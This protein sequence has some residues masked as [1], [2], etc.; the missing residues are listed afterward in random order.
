MMLMKSRIL[1]FLLVL[2]LALSLSTYQ[3]GS[4]LVKINPNEELL[5]IVY[6]LAF[7]HD[8]FVIH[9][10]KYIS[11]V[12][13]WFG[14]Y[15]NHRAVEVLREYFKNAKRI[16]EKDYLLFV[17]DAY[18]LQFS[19]PPEMKRIYTEWQDQELD[20]IVDALRE[21]SRD[22]NFIEF[23]RKHENYYSEDLEVYTSAIALLPPDK[24]MKSYMN[25]TKVRFEFHFPYL[26]CIHGHSF[27]E[28]ISETV[29]YGSGG[30][31]PLVRRNPPQTYWGFLRAKD[32]VFG[33]PLNSVYVNN[34]EFDRVWILEFIYHEL[35]HDLTSPKL[36]EYYGYKVR[37]LRY[38]EDTIEEDMPY[39]ATYDIH[40]W[41]E[42]TMIYESFADGWAYFALSRINK[43]YA[44]L[45]L[46]MQKAWGEFWIEEVVELYEKYARIAVENNKPL[47]EY[48][49][50]ILTEL[51]QKVPE[52]KAKAL[53]KERVPVTPLRALDDVVKEGEVLIVYGTQNPDKS[54]VDYDRKTAEIVR[55]YL[56]RFYSQWTGEIKVEVKSDLEVTDEDL[57]KDLILIGGPASNKVVDQLDEGFPL[58]FVFSNG[59]WILEKNAEFKNVRTFLITDQNIKEIEF[60]S[61]T[62][63][64]PLTSL[65]MAIQNPYRQD[66]YIIWI[67]GTDRYGTRRYKNPTYYLLSYQIYDGRVIEDGFYS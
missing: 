17:L 16:P 56:Q 30:M 39:L 20:K 60:T 35:G 54:G 24:F 38:L 59:T 42:A 33:L 1:A 31:H 9:R 5:S 4:V 7:G 47:D 36:G 2:L 25:S 22:T 67:A 6:Y 66:N 28:K 49:L 65:I 40:F 43:D 13:K 8:E 27:R 57:K 46:E 37:P 64:S 32:T 11:D 19:E 10:G 48:M 34:S 44:E 63:N 52:E 12:E 55:D 62:Y 14:A 26:V 58:R 21:F 61:K 51:A 18:L 29:I 23:F 3:Q 41:G 50:N 15:K 53:Y 45:S